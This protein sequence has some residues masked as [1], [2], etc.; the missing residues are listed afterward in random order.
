M[1]P[2][3]TQRGAATLGIT[4]L[5]LF[6]VML[7]AGIAGRNLLFEQRASANQWRSTQAFEA[8][9]A[10]LEWAQ[11]MLASDAAI[12]ADCRPDAAPGNTPFRERLLA[13]DADTGAFTPRT[14]SDSGHLVA[15]EAACVRAAQG[16][17]CSCPREGNPEL[18]APPAGGAHPAFSIRFVAAGRSGQVQLLAT[19]CDRYAPECLPGGGGPATGGSTAHTQVMLGLLPALVAMPAS[20]LTALGA[21]DADGAM[22]LA[23]TDPHSGGLTAHAGGAITLPNATLQT[24]PGAPAEASIAERDGALAALAADRATNRFFGLDAARWRQLPGLHQIDCPHDC[25]A[26]LQAALSAGQRRIR[27]AG[28][29][30][31]AG[32]ATLGSPGRPILLV[33]EGP[34]QLAADVQ[35]HGAVV[36]LAA[37]CDTSGTH[38]ARID[39][40]LICAGRLIGDGTPTIVYDRAALARLNGEAGVFARIAGSW[41][42]F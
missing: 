35:V 13:Y 40:A 42:D 16:W 8:A 34:L 26:A 41:R 20:A 23:N 10:G 11:T 24:L 3:T 6:V 21:I 7:V 9:E 12:G 4:L 39:G 14:W 15:L 5:M 17:A 33:V 27:I 19:G 18:D 38:G 1:H 28:D 29:V 25:G 22:T 2:A 37:L 32:P 31:I 36:W 30:Q